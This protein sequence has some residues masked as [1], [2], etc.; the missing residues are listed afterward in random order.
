M[1]A[2]SGI[3]GR[4]G[5]GLGRF[6]AG[7]TRAVF[8][9]GGGDSCVLSFSSTGDR[10]EKPAGGNTGCMLDDRPGG[11]L[12][13]NPFGIGGG[14]ADIARGDDGL[15]VAGEEG[16]GE[17]CSAEGLPGFLEDGRCICR[18]EGPAESS[19]SCKSDCRKLGA[20]VSRTVLG[21]G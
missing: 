10:G 14:V 6:G 11:E 3:R 8:S 12:G 9:R 17:C 13:R 21:R 7:G 4:R 2:A 5:L 18:C 19:T 20:E 1:R 16:R 15:E